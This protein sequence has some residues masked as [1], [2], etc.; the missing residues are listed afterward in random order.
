M[1]KMVKYNKDQHPE[2]I[3]GL[4]TIGKT[5][6]EIADLLGITRVTLHR[7]RKKYQD[8]HTASDEGKAIIDKEIEDTLFSRA[9]GAKKLTEK[10]IIKLPDGSTRQEIT[11]KEIAPDTTAMI[12][13]LKNRKPTEWRDKQDVEMS[14]SVGVQIIDDIEDKD[15]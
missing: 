8:C 13:W 3:R 2:L 15:Q 5:D 14:G 6:E 9:T 12:F 10:K 1:I 11:E 4:A 7:W